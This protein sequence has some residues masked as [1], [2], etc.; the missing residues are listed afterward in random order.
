MREKK[1]KG[2]KVIKDQ[3]IYNGRS[4]KKKK[5]KIIGESSKIKKKI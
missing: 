2:T 1:E 5:I 4:W 3:T